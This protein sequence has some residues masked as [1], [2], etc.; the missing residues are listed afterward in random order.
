MDNDSEVDLYDFNKVE[1]NK[2]TE[3]N[4]N[5]VVQHTVGNDE[6]ESHEKDYAKATYDNPLNT[7]NDFGEANLN[8]GREVKVPKTSDKS[9]ETMEIETFISKNEE[10]KQEVHNDGLNN[11]NKYL[12]Q[13]IL[14]LSSK[15][16]EYIATIKNKTTN[17]GHIQSTIS[18]YKDDFN[19]FN[20]IQKEINY[21]KEN[22]IKL[23]T[24]MEGVYN[25]SKIEA[26]ENEI[27]VKKDR[28]NQLKQEE[29]ILEQIQKNHV[30]AIEDLEDRYENK[31]EINLIKLKI[32]TQKEELKMKKEVIKTQ[33]IK[34]KE[35]NN[36]IFQIDV[37]TKQI[38][39]KLELHKNTKNTTGNEEEIISLEKKINELEDKYGTEEK[40]YKGELNAQLGLI[41]KLNE[42]NELLQLQL[43]EKT[44]LAKLNEMKLKEMEKIA[45]MYQVESTNKKDRAVSAN[46]KNSLRTD[47]NNYQHSNIQGNPKLVQ[48][49]NKT[50]G[51]LVKKNNATYN[52]NV[53]NQVQGQVI[54]SNTTNSI[55][56]IKRNNYNN[57]M[58]YSKS[59]VIAKT[60]EVVLPQINTYQYAQQ[61]NKNKDD[62]KS[63][64]LSRI[65]MLKLEVEDLIK[66]NN[67]NI[68]TD[69]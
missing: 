53:I 58:N 35:L 36:Q 7:N 69:H 49:T 1:K 21:Y 48:R 32:Q 50:P 3:D 33:E 42:E 4:E 46:Y 55:D 31:Q 6:F 65:E 64:M 52:K 41:S 51:V 56:N 20:Q 62:Y 24:Q 22:I 9:N 14:V 47:K 15:I 57:R 26:L 30:K 34:I 54:G 63:E 27:K 39:E 2:H 37:K 16:G 61:E 18:H 19:Q 38:K 28:Y 68:P 17:K 10:L 5:S 23:K 13:Q 60:N 45:K 29:S 59:N 12:K 43:K 40:N 67:S 25:I 11:Q 44:R 66:S 8:V